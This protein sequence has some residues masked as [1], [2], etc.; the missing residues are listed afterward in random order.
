MTQN[1][2]LTIGCDPEFFLFKGR[3]PVSAHDIVPGDKLNPHR[4][5][6]GMVQADGTA[7]EFGI[8]PCSTKEEFVSRIDSVLK[9]IRDMI[10]KEYA[11]KFTPTVKYDQAYFDGLPKSAVELG[12]SPDYNIRGARNPRPSGVGTMRTGSGHLHLGWTKDQDITCK[13]HRW[14]CTY[15]VNMLDGY[16][17]SYR[18]FWDKDT[19]RVRMYGMPGAHRPKPYGLEYRSLSNAWLNYPELWPWMFESTQAVFKFCTQGTRGYAIN[20]TE[21]PKEDVSL[22]PNRAV[23]VRTPVDIPT[24]IARTNKQMAMMFSYEKLSPP[25]PFPVDFKAVKGTPMGVIEEQLELEQDDYTGL[26]DG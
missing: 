25:P 14:D 13:H 5:K 10:P 26:I 24:Q 15:L 1:I 21:V 7:V 12:C 6:D 22:H 18:H 2:K 23:Y 16:F 19:E 9:Q 3:K 11:F 8:D 17:Q 4:I 20:R